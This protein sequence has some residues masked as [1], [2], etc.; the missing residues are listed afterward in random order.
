M[1]GIFSSGWLQYVADCVVYMF[2]FFQFSEKAMRSFK[3]FC[4]EKELGAQENKY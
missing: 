1:S 4:E 3:L 2:I